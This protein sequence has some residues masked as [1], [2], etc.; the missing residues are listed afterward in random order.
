MSG[1]KY[2]QFELEKRRQQQL[3]LERQRRIEEEKKKKQLQSSI[4]KEQ[5]NLKQHVEAIN[6]SI[7]QLSQQVKEYELEDRLLYSKLLIQKGK[8]DTKIRD[9]TISYDKNSIPQMETQL[10]RIKDFLSNLKSDDHT[11]LK[12]LASQIESEIALLKDLKKRQ[13]VLQDLNSTVVLEKKI[14]DISSIPMM[15]KETEEVIEPMIDIQKEVNRAYEEFEPFLKEKSAYFYHDVENLYD[16]ICSIANNET[17]DPEYKKS[18]IELRRKTLLMNKGK[19]EQVLDLLALE[20]AQHEELVHHYQSLCELLNVEENP[21]YEAK[22]HKETLKEE[23]QR[24]N[25]QYTEKQEI[26]YI[27]QSVHEVMEKL[28]YDILATDYMVKRKNSVHHHIY[29]FGFEQA[30]NVFVSDNGSIL[31]E[32]TGISEGQSEMTSLEK[33]KVTEAMDAFC[34]H[35]VEIREELKEKGIYLKNESLSPA[36]ER[37][38]RKIDISNKKRV[39]QRQSGTTG[40]QSKKITRQLN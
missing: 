33:L 5:E 14:Y 12:E 8:T 23:I 32:V 4:S 21:L 10:K 16:S 37:Y 13:Q 30:V 3:E 11:K 25:E 31:F 2:S 20:R 27:V 19:Y 6:H 38:A 40:K 35:Y 34:T 36:D 26:E 28:G 17:Y 24:L 9:F 7:D 22:E 15:V 39:K 18:Q 29:E 1:P